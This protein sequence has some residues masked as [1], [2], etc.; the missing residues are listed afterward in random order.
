MTPPKIS[1]I[2]PVYNVNADLLK[3]CIGSILNQT[4]Q[5]FEISICD[6]GSTKTETIEALAE[7]EILD[8]RIIVNYLPKNKGI[9]VAS[10]L[11][12]KSA[13]G[14][15][16]ALLDND[17]TISA[18]TLEQFYNVIQADNSVD[19]I[20]TDESKQEMDNTLIDPYLKPTFSKIHLMSVMYIL[21]MMCFKR[22]LFDEVNGF[23]ENLSGAQ[24]YDLCLRITDKAHK[25]VHIPYILYYWRKA[26]GSVALRI[27]ESK[28]F[29]IQAARR[30]ITHYANKTY[31]GSVVEDG[32][33]E[34]SFRVRP[35]LATTPL[36]SLIIPTND[37]TCQ[38]AKRGNINLL[39]N[40]LNSIVKKTTYKN[41]EIIV[42]DNG[43]ASEETKQTIESID[44]ASLY[45]FSYTEDNF[46]FADKANFAFTKC[47]GEYVVML[48][49]DMEVIN[50][51]WI[52][53]QLECMMFKGVGIV[54]SLLLFED[55]TIQHAGV[56]LSGELGCSHIFY[57]FKNSTDI[58]W[59]FSHLIREYSAVTGA[60]MMVKKSL[61][62]ELGGFDNSFALDYNDIDFNLRARELGYKVVYT[63]YSKFYHFESRTAKRNWPCRKAIT[64]FKE[65][66][67][68]LIENDPFFHKNFI[69]NEYR[70]FV[71]DIKSP[72][73][74][75]GND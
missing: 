10:N 54:G 72:P 26:P 62:D 51:D 33:L 46:N 25:I 34:G 67:S 16:I 53:A 6:D 59:G 60:G 56:V 5:D 40:F 55:N 73:F 74:K 42:V 11:A 17:D 39:Q 13:S 70:K 48:N 44:K 22:S 41:Y 47:K 20:Y 7:I 21:H 15:F 65:R 63:P 30:A 27:D 8:P 71:L 14:D 45:S 37:K 31:P 2:I 58:Y 18:N 38:I 24:D 57:S 68:H 36:V 23:N 12:I 29:A 35:K 52:Q 66:W 1:V 61:L 50:G 69:K 49:D 28:K 64:K 75:Y 9:A 3:K 19:F 43:N 32:L 4:Y